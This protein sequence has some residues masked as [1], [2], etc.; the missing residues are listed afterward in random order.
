MPPFATVNK[1]ENVP[2]GDEGRR[3]DALLYRPPSTV[4]R[5]SSNGIIITVMAV[6]SAQFISASARRRGLYTL[7]A[8]TFL[9][10][11]GFFMIIPLLSIYYVETLGWAAASIGL[12]LAVRQFA[13]QGLTLISGALA[14]RLGAKGLIL[15][16]LLVRML[17]FAAMAWANTFPLLLLSAF[18]AAVGGSLF[19]SPTKAA[20]AALTEEKDRSRY[21]ALNGVVS[22]IGLTLGTQLGVFL[23]RFDFA[24]VCMVAAA[25]YVVT[26]LVTL[27]FLPS[28]RVASEG[29]NLTSGVR[30]AFKDRPFMLYNALLMGFWF[31]WVQITISLPLAAKL[32]GGGPDTVGWIFAINSALTI[33]LQYPLM[34]LTSDR[35]QP[36]SILISGCTIMAIGL[37]G[38]ALAGNVAGLLVCVVLFALGS[39]LASPSQQTVT[40]NLANPVALGSYFG[41]S[42]LALAIGGGLGNL[43][44]GLL[45]D[46]GRSLAFPELP[47]LVFLVV[48]LSSS[49]GLTLMSGRQRRA[50]HA[51]ATITAETAFKDEAER[52]TS[53]FMGDAAK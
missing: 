41:V 42:S 28:V 31:M 46:L 39:L 21:F 32:V 53:T 2:G 25:T 8:D 6:A 1:A 33:V 11:A 48:G 3:A 20:T 24:L 36:M 14:D 51:Q 29:A 7:L 47:W 27:F 10:W 35:F 30:L 43:S 50:R 37:G 12:V 18:L 34:R 44:G 15:A 4:Y 13:Q 38:V 26:F 19:D 5:L 49:V 22:Q 17:G 9:M 52:P 40:A 45:Y 23:L 16:G